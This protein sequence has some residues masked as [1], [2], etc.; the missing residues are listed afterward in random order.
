MEQARKGAPAFADKPRR[1][2]LFFIE[3][4]GHPVSGRRS[5]AVSW[6]RAFLENLRANCADASRT[7]ATCDKTREEQESGRAPGL[8]G[9]GA[10]AQEGGGRSSRTRFQGGRWAVKQAEGALGLRGGGCD[11]GA[12]GAGRGRT[13]VANPFSG[14]ARRGQGA[15]KGRMFVA[16]PLSWRTRVRRD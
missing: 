1:Q 9:G 15:G 4:R 5:V 3:P 13:F 6:R 12:S 2:G 14:R 11:G 8:T 16:H 7:S 10:G